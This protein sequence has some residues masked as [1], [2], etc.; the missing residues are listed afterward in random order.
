MNEVVVQGWHDKLDVNRKP[1]FVFIGCWPRQITNIMHMMLIKMHGLLSDKTDC[2]T[3]ELK[4][5]IN[6]VY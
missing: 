3:K 1:I 6:S 2:Q 5:G 4:C